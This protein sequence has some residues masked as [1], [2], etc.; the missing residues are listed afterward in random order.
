VL[1]LRRVDDLLQSFRG[2]LGELVQCRALLPPHRCTWESMRPGRSAGWSTTAQPSGG[3]KA[4]G[5]TPAI[6]PP[7]RGREH[8]RGGAARRR[9]RRLPGSRGRCLPWPAIRAT[10]V[11]SGITGGES[12]GCSGGRPAV[13]GYGTVPLD[14]RQFGAPAGGRRGLGR[15]RRGS[16]APGEAYSLVVAPAA[17][18]G[19]VRPEVTV[20]HGGLDPPPRSPAA[21]ARSTAAPP[22]R[23][24]LPGRGLGDW[25]A[26][27]RFDR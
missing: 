2:Q 4:A 22:R 15:E 9:R 1:L 23:G 6:T 10:T 8:R 20:D 24:P 14:H 7:P 18:P 25:L 3:G 17:E 16:A 12:S 27:A 13:P 19:L 5:S 26:P 11:A 21:R